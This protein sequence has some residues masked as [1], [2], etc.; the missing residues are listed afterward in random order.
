MNK[1]G[2]YS[3]KAKAV[4][5]DRDG[6]IN[7]MCYHQEHG[8]IDSPANP[9]QFKLIAGI[10]KLIKD[11]KK[12]GYLVIV[13]SNQPGIAKKKY[14]KRLFNAINQK[15]HKLLEKEETK[16]DDVYY[17]LHHPE[18]KDKNYKAICEC[19]KPKPGLILRAAKDHNLNL[20]KSWFVGDGIVDIQA[21]KTAGCKT[22]LVA[23]LKL[24]LCQIL[25]KKSIRPNF[26]VSDLNWVLKTIEEQDKIKSL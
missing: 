7:E 18:A 16:L 5:L 10:G 23:K 22:I 21:G 14:T 20:K 19:R 12:L 2:V 15:M 3:K 9:K 11:L 25:I 1:R 24:D 17:C 13:I 6:I 8:L 26:V 4:F